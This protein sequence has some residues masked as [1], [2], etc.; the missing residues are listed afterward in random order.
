[1]CGHQVVTRQGAVAGSVWWSCLMT[2]TAAKY[3][4]GST[5]CAG[6]DSEG[7]GVVIVMW[8]TVSVV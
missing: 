7:G 2:M 4:T 1:M 3:S 6:D 8:A 5:V